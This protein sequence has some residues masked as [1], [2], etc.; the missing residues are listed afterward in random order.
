M[1]ASFYLLTANAE[2]LAEFWTTWIHELRVVGLDALNL[3]RLAKRCDPCTGELLMILDIV[4]LAPDETVFNDAIAAVSEE[5]LPHWKR[6]IDLVT[7]MAI[8]MAK[9][10]DEQEGVFQ[11]FFQA[12]KA[13]PNM[14]SF[15]EDAVMQAAAERAQ[16]LLKEEELEHGKYWFMRKV[17]SRQLP[18]ILADAAWE[19]Q[20]FDAITFL[21]VWRK[22]HFIGI[23]HMAE[24]WAKPPN[25]TCMPFPVSV[26][27]IGFELETNLQI[28]ERFRVSQKQNLE[29]NL[30]L[31][32][33]GLRALL[34]GW[35]PYEFMTRISA[36][37]PKPLDMSA[38][39]HRIY[40]RR[41][42]RAKRAGETP[43]TP[44][45]T[46]ETSE[47]ESLTQEE[48]NDLLK[49]VTQEDVQGMIKMVEDF[50]EEYSGKD[51]TEEKIP[52]SDFLT[53]EEVAA[54]LEAPSKP[55]RKMPKRKP[56][57]V[58]KSAVCSFAL[59]KSG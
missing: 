27:G 4:S 23:E 21:H 28:L 14:P 46:K 37:M 35:S 34:L 2:S 56:M 3:P 8:A 51:M 32:A 22:T 45:E 7:E 41:E 13:L 26:L 50:V 38:V 40:K 31:M 42:K 49:G 47:Q 44:A 30:V 58:N 10:Y 1:A 6:H 24:R 25:I 20:L 53:P 48:V 9:H 12:L 39:M 36:T 15:D 29:D 5:W 54:L 59:S 43:A 11:E 19:K 18:W 57:G 52:A 17:P 33:D 55:R 16:S